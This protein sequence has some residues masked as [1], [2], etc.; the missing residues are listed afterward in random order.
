VNAYMLD[1]MPVKG[2]LEGVD[3]DKSDG[4]IWCSKQ[5]R[6]GEVLLHTYSRVSSP[7]LGLIDVVYVNYRFPGTHSRA[8]QSACPKRKKAVSPPRSFQ[9]MTTYLMV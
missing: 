3:N 2:F 9:A 4:L 8:K 7:S 1:I 5:R 6:S